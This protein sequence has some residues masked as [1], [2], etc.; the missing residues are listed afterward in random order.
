MSSRS[1]VRRLLFALLLSLAALATP[2][3]QTLP[4]TPPASSMNLAEF[5]GLYEYRDGSTLYMVAGGGRLLAIIGDGKYPLRPGGPDTFTN[6]SGDMIPFTRDGSGRVVAFSERGDTFRRRSANV[7]P[8]VRALFE[9]RPRGPDGKPRAYRYT[10]P[11]R[12]PDGIRVAEA[13][14]KDFPPDAADRLVNG[15]ID[16]TYPDVRSIL[17]YH[18]NALRLEEYFYGFERDRPHQMRSLTKSIVSLLAGVAVDRKLLR[19]NEP[20]L[21]KLGYGSYGNP[22]PRK[23]RI[24]LT[25]LL[26]NRSGLACNDHDGASPGNEVKLYEAADWPKAFVDLPMT[27][28]PG[29]VGRYCSGGFFTVGRILERVV[30]KSLAE[31]ANEALLAPLGVR[32]DHWKWTFKL[33]RSHRDDFGQ[34][35]L[36]PRDLLKL[37]ILI[38]Q[39]G[40]WQGRRIVS[41]SWIDAAIAKQSRVDDSDYGLGIWHRWYGVRT[42]AGERRVDTIMLSGNGGQKLYLVPS[43]NLIVVFTGGAFNAESPVNTMMARVLLPA[44]LEGASAPDAFSSERGGR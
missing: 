42:N 43:L 1:H 39:R 3:S 8:D 17:V 12:L 25:D 14:A 5:E 40:Q 28:D 32:R 16:G 11:A 15:V 26:S 31:F 22:D 30:G 18:R 38:Q 13:T 2:R 6:G 10:P 33:D 41:A 20:V 24:T 35:Y 34:I 36:R 37:G 21:D 29:T 27:A 19:A 44:L 4:I 23:A 7:P 9:P